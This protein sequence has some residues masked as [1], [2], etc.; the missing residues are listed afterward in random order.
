MYSRKTRHVS[1]TD[2]CTACWQYQMISSFASLQA[3][4]TCRKR[5]KKKAEYTVEKQNK[6]NTYR[7]IEG[8]QHTAARMVSNLQAAR[9][10]RKT[11]QEK[12]RIH[13]VEKKKQHV[14]H[15]KSIFSMH[16]ST[17]GQAVSIIHVDSTHHR[18]KLTDN[19]QATAEVNQPLSFSLHGS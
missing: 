12:N 16:R 18:Y 15:H 6:K 7:I 4:R 5:N 14:S 17:H 13:T 19:T 1:L 10:C 2:P 9:T 11:E 3:A 8:A